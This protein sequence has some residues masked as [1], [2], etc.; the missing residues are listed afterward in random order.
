MT[1]DFLEK[2]NEL[3]YERKF[4]ISKGLMSENELTLTVKSNPNFF[5]EIYKER[6]INSIYFDTVSFDLYRENEMGIAKRFKYRIRWYGD[7]LQRAVKPILEIK[8]KTGLTGDKWLYPL[9]DFDVDNFRGENVFSKSDIPDLIKEKMKHLQPVLVNTYMRKYYLSKDERFRLTTDKDMKFY[10]F[11]P[12]SGRSKLYNTCGT[13]FVVELKYKPLDDKTA[14]KITNKF[15]FRLDK[16]SKY[17][18]GCELI[19]KL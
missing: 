16:F 6:Q 10:R 14:N 15:P 3:R 4:P 8:V 19:Y 18:T 12:L 17:A 9:N 5:R 13:D 2:R 11:L 1:L 7:N